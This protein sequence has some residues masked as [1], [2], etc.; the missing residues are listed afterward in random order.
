MI[1]HTMYM[2]FTN[3][4]N[5]N[6]KINILIILSVIS[7]NIMSQVIIPD[8]TQGVSI[9]KYGKPP[10]EFSVLDVESTEKG[11]LIPNVS[12]TVFEGNISGFP[13]PD[14][15]NDNIDVADGL[16][17]FVTEPPHYTGYW[18]YNQPSN[19]WLKLRSETNNIGNVPLGGILPYSGYIITDGVNAN[20]NIN[21][22]G[23]IDTQMEGWY[24]CNGQNQTP[25]LR[26]RFIVGAKAETRYANIANT[27]GEAKHKLDL[28]ELPEHT[29]DLSIG[30]PFLGP[31]PNIIEAE[32][33]YNMEY[34]FD[35]PEAPGLTTDLHSDENPALAGHKHKIPYYKR[36]Y[37]ADNS[38]DYIINTAQAGSANFGVMT[39]GHSH[40]VPGFSTGDV[41]ATNAINNLLMSD[42]GSEHTH[43]V[44][45]NGNIIDIYDNVNGGEAQPHENRPHYYTVIYL[46]WVGSPGNNYNEPYLVPRNQ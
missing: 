5:N 1:R 32:L 42:Q 12:L 34:Q 17:V 35:A 46:I 22:T 28:H 7:L 21:G 13:N 44:S 15:G 6:M 43:A 36:N 31:I 30:I 24:I 18:F 16:I 37:D 3:L 20:F 33:S 45:E 8:N 9:N 11:V 39:G 23:K 40:D 41:V 4:N 26:A 19:E 25:D 10:S 14:V 27:D 29:H 38:D 2:F